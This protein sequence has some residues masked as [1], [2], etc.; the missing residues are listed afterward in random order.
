MYSKYPRT[1]HLPWSPGASPNDDK[2]MSDVNGLLNVPIVITEKMDGGNV[3][4]ERDNCFARSHGQPPTHKSYDAFKGLHARV[5]RMIHP[6]TQLFGEW[7]YAKHA[8][9]YHDLPH[10]LMLFGMRN[11]ETGRWTHWGGVQDKANELGVGVV[12]VL[13]NTRVK[14]ARDLEATTKRLVAIPSEFG[15]KEGVVIR[16]L[17]PFNDED[18]T[19]CLGKWVRANHITDKGFHWKFK[20]IEKNGLKK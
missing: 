1:Y 20:T 13:C 15:E 17:Q 10:Y 9:H 2:S 19:R 16:R 8:I 3:C 7:L 18:F 12:P 11:K 6:N 5:K 4:L 14:T